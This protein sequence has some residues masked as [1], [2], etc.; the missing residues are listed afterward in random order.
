MRVFERGSYVAR[1]A[2]PGVPYGL[3]LT[4]HAQKRRG[5]ASVS[6]FVVSAFFALRG[7]T[8]LDE[9]VDLAQCGFDPCS[10]WSSPGA[11]AA[12]DCARHSFGPDYNYD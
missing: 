12:A 6:G 7:T 4:P 2:R 9:S 3:L 10:P 11:R 1:A 8:L 5:G